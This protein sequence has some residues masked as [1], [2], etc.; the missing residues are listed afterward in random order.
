[1]STKLKQIR[2]T[3]PNGLMNYVPMSNK[4]SLEHHNEIL[5]QEGRKELCMKLETVEMTQEE[6]DAEPPVNPNFTP[7]AK[8]S[9]VIAEK[10][11]EITKLRKQLA[12]AEAN[13][14]ELSKQ[15]PAA[16]AATTPAK[17]NVQAAKTPAAP[18]ADKA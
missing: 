10:D 4:A 15:T 1:M 3:H 6:F 7:A 2:V 11:D 5:I 8:A 18:A 12:E 16:P 9:E 14:K 17:A 13:N